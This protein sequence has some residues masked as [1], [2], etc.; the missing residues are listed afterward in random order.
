MMSPLAKAVST[1]VR[2]IPRQ[3]LATVFTPTYQGWGNTPNSLEFEILNKVIR[4]RVLSDSD[5]VGGI[6]EYI[7]LTGLPFDRTPDQMSVVHIPLVRTNGRFITSVLYLNYLDYTANIQGN[8]M[9]NF[10]NCSITPLSSAAGALAQS[11]SGAG[12][13]GTA[14]LDLI[15]ENTVLIKEPIYSPQ[16]AV[17]RCILSNDKELSNL[18]IRNFTAFGELCT[19]AVKAHIY[20]E[21]IITIDE[22]VAQAGRNIAAFRDVISRY[23]SAEEEYII[24]LTRWKRILFMNDRESNNRFIRG[25]VSIM[26]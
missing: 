11:F 26:H 4:P 3:I 25:Q 16:N 14:R 2:K 15:A 22:G 7:R 19:L 13:M 18:S 17:L 20:N 9:I 12:V 21:M 6:E 1:V 10:N 5:V 23:E 24:F 8:S